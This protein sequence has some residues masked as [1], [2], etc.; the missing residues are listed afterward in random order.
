VILIE[1]PGE[2]YVV[3]PEK[4]IKTTATDITADVG[5]GPRSFSHSKYKVTYDA[6]VQELYVPPG[7]N[8]PKGAGRLVDVIR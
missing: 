7:H 2:A 6:Q 5:D 8:A 1:A 3:A 4:V